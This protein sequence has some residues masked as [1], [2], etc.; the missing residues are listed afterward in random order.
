MALPIEPIRAAADRVASSLGLEVVEVEFGGAGKHRAL[1]VFVEKDAEGRAKLAALAATEE[2]AAV[3][4]KGVPAE[5]LS[6]TTHED[7][8]AF[9]ND[10]GTVL[11]VEDLVP[12]AEYTLEVSS[13]GLE[14]RLH[15]PADFRRFRGSL[16]KLQTFHPV[17]GNR[18]FT[19]RL[20]EADETTLTLDLRGVKQKGKAKKSV[21]TAS[22]AVAVGFE[23]V[24]KANLIAEI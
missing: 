14:R 17:E 23:N 10:F 9:A 24:E 13:P 16:V 21:A 15:K 11:D 4:P 19:G 3:L 7:C 2:G 22:P 1:R 18:H 5:L 8:A 20:T 12:G 6:G